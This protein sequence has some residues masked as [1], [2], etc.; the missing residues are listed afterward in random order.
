MEYLE[1]F[2]CYNER[3]NSISEL[4]EITEKYYNKV[5]ILHCPTLTSMQGI[6]SQT[7]LIELN[8]S[9]NA[10][11]RIEG[12]QDMHMLQVLNLS[13]NNIR[14]INCLAG[15]YSLQK[16]NLSFNKISS[17]FNIKQLYGDEYQNFSQFDVR[18]NNIAQVGEIKYLAGCVHL[19]DVAFQGQS[20]SNPVCKE[21]EYLY[22]AVNSM[23][24]LRFLDH[25]QIST[26]VQSVKM[27]K[28]KE[29][30]M[31]KYEEKELVLETSL[32]NN[33]LDNKKLQQ[34]LDELFDAYKELSF[35]Y[36]NREDYWTIC[37]KS[38]EEHKNRTDYEKKEY[39][40]ECKRLRRKLV[41]KTT[42]ISNLKSKTVVPN[43]EAKDKTLEDLHGQMANLMRDLGESQRMSQQALDDVYKKQEKLKILEKNNYELKNELKKTDAK[44]NQL[45]AKSIESATVAFRKY[46]E[47]QKKY[48]DLIGV[49]EEK[50]FEIAGLKKKNNEI[51]ELNGK[52]DENWSQKYREAVHNRENTISALREEVHRLTM[53]EKEKSQQVVYADKEENRNKIWELE[54]K[55]ALQ[56]SE[57]K[58]KQR[59]TDMKYQDFIRENSDL[60]EMLKMSVEKE[61]KSKEIIS[62]LT[63]LIRAL[64]VQLDKELS[65]KQALKRQYDEKSCI[66]DSELSNYKGKNEAL[67]SRLEIIEKDLNIGDD[68]MHIKNREIAKLKREILELN[69]TIEDYEEKTKNF[70]A[71]L[72]KSERLLTNEIDELVE[73]NKEFELTIDTKNV[74]ITDQAESIKELKSLISQYEN[75]I[76][77]YQTTRNTY[78]ENYEERLQD[79]YDEIEAL[80]NKL[81]NTENIIS[82]IESQVLDLDE[83]RNQLKNDNSK[84]QE[85][86][87]EKNEVIEFVEAE[88]ANIKLEKDTEVS[89]ILEEKNTIISDLKRF[90]DEL[91][92]KTISQEKDLKEKT[93]KIHQLEFDLSVLSKNLQS[94]ISQTS[95]MREEIRALLL[96][97]DNQKKQASEKISQL[98]KLFS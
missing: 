56:V 89:E 1:E 11:Q 2:S 72:E 91:T 69:V 96:E 75:E 47:L 79:A 41:S 19:D 68:T 57:F 44:M 46:E 30:I 98:S 10:I 83:K 67:K 24:E 7:Q 78:K 59:E 23:K 48:E 97:M 74:I 38:L 54:Q 90:R 26:L 22:C 6:E 13:C 60:K 88:I 37:V 3:I 58:E 62:E 21:S 71:K 50:E 93:S 51:L 12:L 27:P 36:K 45:H 5:R 28:E 53:M 42:K 76:D 94:E 33:K 35:K 39:Q 25:Q 20:G 8:L 87:R 92:S 49:V 32:E 17:L 84:M 43:T 85:Q 80:K 40:N 64:Q 95:E 29:E 81:A 77:K 52:F 70:R 55:L 34:D 31:K 63:D 61:A 86:L 66:F 73:Q 16:L 15:L 82:E 4:A 65:E 9:S 14:V 18:G